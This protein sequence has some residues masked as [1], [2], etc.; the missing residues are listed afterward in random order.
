[1]TPLYLAADRGSKGVVRVLLTNKA[2][3]NA[4]SH[5][6]TPLHIAAANG[7]ADV[8]E[9]QRQRGGEE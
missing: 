9:L 1:M 8:V 3:V 7:H 2:E 4:R 6:G 5:Y